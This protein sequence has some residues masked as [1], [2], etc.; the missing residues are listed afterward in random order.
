MKQ[1]PA[2]A[3]PYQEA[4]DLDK[5][6]YNEEMLAYKKGT[7]GKSTSTKVSKDSPAL[8][9]SKPKSKGLGFASV[10]TNSAKAKKTKKVK[11]VK[12]PNAP[13]KPLAA[14]VVG[15]CPPLCSNCSRVICKQQHVKL[16]FI[17]CVATICHH[18]PICWLKAQFGNG[19]GWV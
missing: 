14:Y 8:A 11:K 5:V 12:D 10:A 1:I 9:A 16:I 19:F 15:G 2:D 6:R 3:E 13:K 17:P 4:A 7:F 18:H